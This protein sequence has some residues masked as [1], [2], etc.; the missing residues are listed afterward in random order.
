MHVPAKAKRSFRNKRP[1]PP[2][3]I[4]EDQELL[5]AQ[6]IGDVPLQ[7]NANL[8]ALMILHLIDSHRN[9][10]TTSPPIINSMQVSIVIE[11]D[12][13][14]LNS[15]ITSH[16]TSENAIPFFLVRQRRAC[17]PE[18][19]RTTPIMSMSMYMCETGAC[20]QVVGVGA[21]VKTKVAG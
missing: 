8:Q 4:L 17:S 1:V 2:Q 19:Y 12:L 11:C 7:R 3:E 14:S 18:S 9:C 10:P 5:S 20:F 13:V 15:R 16:P 21:G 6:M